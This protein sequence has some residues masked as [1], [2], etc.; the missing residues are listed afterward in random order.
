M[1]DVIVV[2]DA[3]A[4]VDWALALR[5]FRKARVGRCWDEI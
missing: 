2:E 3:D 4:D 5:L 1:A